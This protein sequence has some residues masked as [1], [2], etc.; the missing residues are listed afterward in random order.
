VVLGTW[1]R[2]WLIEF[3][4]DTSGGEP[5]NSPDKHC[6]PDRSEVEGPA[7]STIFSAASRISILHSLPEQYTRHDTPETIFSGTIFSRTIFSK[8]ISSGMI[9]P[10]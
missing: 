2:W 9:S 5:R 6:H 3:K 10:A 8:T 1:C 7:F 4:R